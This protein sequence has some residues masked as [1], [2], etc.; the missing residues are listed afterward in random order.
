M[1]GTNYIGR[2]WSFNNRRLGQESKIC[3]W[4]R[5]CFISGKNIWLKKCKVIHTMLTGPGSPIFETFWCDQNEFLLYELKRN[6]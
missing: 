4:P 1:F 5:K 2:D 3:L 6:K